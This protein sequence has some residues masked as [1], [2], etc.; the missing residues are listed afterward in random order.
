MELGCACKNC[1]VLPMCQLKDNCHIQST[2]MSLID[3]IATIRISFVINMNDLQGC[4]EY[5]KKIISGS[6]MNK[7]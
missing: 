2:S 6:I 7:E 1:I 4:E 5:I 3:S